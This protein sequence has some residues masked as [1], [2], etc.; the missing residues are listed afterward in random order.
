MLARVTVL[1]ACGLLSA[2]R[3]PPPAGPLSADFQH[4]VNYAHIH[5]PGR[6]YG[7]DVSARELAALHELGV[8]WIVIPPFGYQPGVNAAEIVGFA[9]RPRTAE[10][11]HRSDPTLTDQ[12]L[13]EEIAH[14]H[15][16]GMRVTL[17]PHL[18]S[19]DFWDGQQWAGT[20]DQ[21][22]P[23]EHARWWADYREFALHFAGVAAETGADQYCLG[24][25]LVQMTTRYPREW[26]ALAAEVRQ[27]YHGPVLYAAHWEREFDQIRFWDALDFVGITAYFPL[28]AP[29]GASVE[30][31]VAAWRPHRQRIEQLQRAVG[32]PVLFLEIG[33]RAVADCYRRPWEYA[34]GQRDLD[35]QARAYEAVFRAFADA[36][37][38]R[39]LYWWKTFTDPQRTES[40]GDGTD[41][42]FRDRPAERVIAEWY[43]PHRQR[44]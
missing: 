17:T 10:F 22:T 12:N 3:P 28:D 14:A 41:F 37:W 40:H 8:D 15:A 42:T 30:Q 27:V 7:S 9:H 5:R 36:P 18:W 11:S 2:C 43:G 39:G 20:V 35:A 31:L 23:A 13:R 4:G 1:V 25:E 32:K 38:W 16:L 44:K 21:H 26:R 24:T 19:C 29:V 33:Y 34:G 6:G